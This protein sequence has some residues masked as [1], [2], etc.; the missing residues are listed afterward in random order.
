MSKGAVLGIFMEFILKFFVS[1]LNVDANTDR[2]EQ[3]R[4]SNDQNDNKRA[5]FIITTGSGGLVRLGGVTRLVGNLP[6]VSIETNGLAVNVSVVQHNVVVGE[7]SVSNDISPL[8]GSVLAINE[9]L[10]GLLG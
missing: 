1:L 7:K 8:W 5:T 9:E 10:T 2:N 6:V 4:T 3:K